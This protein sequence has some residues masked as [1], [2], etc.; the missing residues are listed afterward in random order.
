MATAYFCPYCG[1]DNAPGEEL[2]RACQQWL[3][4]TDA[5]QHIVPLLNERYEVLTQIGSGGFGAVYKAR[6]TRD[7]NRFVAIKQIN[8]SGLSAQEVIEATDAFNREAQILSTLSHPFLPRIFDRFSDPEHWYLVMNF[9]AGQTLDAYLQECVANALP[10]HAGLPLDE[11]LA[12]GLQLCD[13]LHYLHSQQPAV[14]FRDLKP[15]NIMRTT[16][17]SLYLIDFG[18]ARHFKPGQAR[19]TIPFGSPGFAAPEQYGKAQTTPRTDIY[20][21]G[22]LLYCL[23]TGDDP[24]E[25]PFDFPSLRFPRASGTR[26]L[27]TLIQRMVALDP[28]QRPA[29]VQEVRRELQN[30][31]NIHKP[32][33]KQA[34]IWLRIM[35]FIWP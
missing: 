31:Q 4:E 8:L 23:L 35:R 1:A 12:I 34:S 19:D 18:I 17:Q 11:T 21:L 28:E 27:E 10:V 29:D 16:G 6:D 9:I 26:E 2:C 22:A 14:I 15:G 7:D 3:A 5:A 24:S 13:V 25:H 32:A 30:I 33:K 20:S